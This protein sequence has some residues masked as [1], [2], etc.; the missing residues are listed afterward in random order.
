MQSFFYNE[1]FQGRGKAKA[2][3]FHIIIYYN[4]AHIFQGGILLKL[5]RQMF[6]FINCKLRHSLRVRQFEVSH[7]KSGRIANLL[8]LGGVSGVVLA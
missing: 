5:K 3:G 2:K 6:L 7:E 4:A 1:N 8:Y